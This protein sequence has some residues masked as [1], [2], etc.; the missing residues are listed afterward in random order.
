MSGGATMW[1]VLEAYFP[2]HPSEEAGWVATYAPWMDT[3]A[4]PGGA[5]NA[6]QGWYALG[7][8]RLQE[9]KG[10]KFR[11]Q[12]S[13]LDCTGC[14]NCANICPAKKKALIMKPIG[15]QT[16]IQIPNHKFFTE[17][18]VIDDL[19]SVASVKGSQFRQPLFEFSGACAGC[20][21]TPYI[22]VITQ[23]CGDRMMIA[24]ATGCSYGCCVQIWNSPERNT[25]AVKDCAVLVP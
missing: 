18:P 21:E 25:A 7:A 2:F 15:S 12:I 17:L 16:E 13:P 10:L 6:W 19:M 8:K 9:L 4:D 14:G 11:I 24:K 5:Q 1:G 3:F 23:Y 22:K 20:G